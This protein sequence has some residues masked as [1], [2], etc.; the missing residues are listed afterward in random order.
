MVQWY[1]Q[2]YSLTSLLICLLLYLFFV[3]ICPDAMEMPSNKKGNY[4][5]QDVEPVCR[6]KRSFSPSYGSKRAMF[7][8]VELFFV[9]MS[10]LPTLTAKTWQGY[11]LISF[12]LHFCSYTRM[13][14]IYEV[15]IHSV[16]LCVYQ[17]YLTCKIVLAVFLKPLHLV[18]QSVSVPEESLPSG[19]K[20]ATRQDS[21]KR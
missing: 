20:R 19:S 14:Y 10:M 13:L 16:Q 11:L 17:E 1:Y 8:V 21:T 2:M 3:C 5:G 9:T 6:Q 18:H 15:S 7:S 4:S 12:L